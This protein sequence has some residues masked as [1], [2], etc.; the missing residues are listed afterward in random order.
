MKIS[1]KNDYSEGCHPN[2]LEALVKN[3]LQQQEGYGLDEYCENAKDLIL[4]KLDSKSS[5]VFF[6]SGGTQA[7]LLVISS[8]L[9]PFESVISAKTGHIFSNETGAIEATGHKIN[10]TPATNGKLSPSNIQLVL[11][12]H[13]KQPHQLKPKLVFISNA[14][15]IGTIYSK[16]ELQE[17][18]AFCTEKEL[19]LY[20]DGAR[21]AHALTAENN[22]LELVDLANLVDVFYLGGTKNGALIGEAIVINNLALQ[23]N[24]EYYI[25][26]KGA[27]LAK[28]RLLGI[29]FQELFKNDL[30]FKLAIH[31][32]KQAMRIK[33]AFISIESKFLSD[34]KTNQIFPILKNAQ[35]DKLS[36]EFDF[37]IWDKIDKDYSA[38]RVIT[39]WA[40]KEEDVDSFIKAIK[41]IQR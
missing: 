40:T 35:I 29:Q 16:K 41:N 31:A 32:N 21:L 37:H 15:E 23:K 2:I 36:K 6:V 20:L 13:T 3:N 26:Q 18:A 12:N 17:L 4:D 11:D 19:Y 33:E 14:T 7:N 30:Y 24:F 8:I 39:S 28:G 27:M 34:T 9:R 25:K 5:K 10:A 38:I 1:F 22:D